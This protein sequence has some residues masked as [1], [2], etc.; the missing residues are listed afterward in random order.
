MNAETNMVEKD[1]TAD[2]AKRVLA[3][4]QTGRSLAVEGGG[5]KYSYGRIIKADD[6]M[7]LREHSGVV[8]YDP[9]ELVITARAGTP[10]SHIHQTL[11]EQ[12]QMLP[13]EPP[14]FSHRATIGGVVAT[15]LSGASR[16]YF[17]GVRDHM[18]G[19]KIIN[20][21]AE[22]LKFGGEVM[23][24]VAG[25]DIS[26]LMVGA[27]GILGVL[28]EV[29]I[30]VMPKPAAQR[31]LTF[32]MPLEEAMDFLAERQR[33]LLPISA[34][35]W[36]E[37]VLYL[38]L[39]G[40]EAA[41]AAVQK[42]LGGERKSDADA[43]SF[44]NDLREQKLPFFTKDETPL[45]RLSVPANTELPQSLGA[46]LVEWGGA[47]RWV[48][49]ERPMDEIQDAVFGGHVRR[50]RILS[51]DD[52]ALRIWVEDGEAF[53]PLPPTLMT[54]HQRLKSAFDPKHILNPGRMYKDL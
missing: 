8:R 17:G 36:Q 18:L 14:Q 22:V 44:W 29:S 46:Q 4:F 20:G 47:L 30:R 31:T 42:E 38:R 41:L 39:S 6:M 11:A 25:Y 12:G 33:R 2:L 48:K 1:I 40:A 37:G 5:S 50:F 43:D 53:S 10:L 26:R 52:G 3:A 21:K 34:S 27:M 23:K 32:E 16:P 54:L 13:F 9:S 24:N 35:A 45:W 51:T 49:S 15:G 19:V 7:S 28:L